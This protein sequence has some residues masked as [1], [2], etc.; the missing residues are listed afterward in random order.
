[1]FIERKVSHPPITGVNKNDVIQGLARWAQTA[2]PAGR[3]GKLTASTSQKS[4]K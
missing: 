1:M 2:S 4:K 3:G